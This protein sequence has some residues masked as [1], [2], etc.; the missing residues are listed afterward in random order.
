MILLG[1]LGIVNF[2]IDKDVR[3][4]ILPLHKIPLALQT[5]VKQELDNL[6]K[7]NIISL[8]NKPTECMSQMAVVKKS[9]GDLRICIDPQPLNAVLLTM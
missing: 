6:V 5:K 4:K 8:V 9:N 1:D 7:H 3:P 2:K